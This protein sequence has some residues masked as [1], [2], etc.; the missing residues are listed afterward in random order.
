MKT[1]NFS[2][3]SRLFWGLHFALAM[4]QQTVRDSERLTKLSDGK[5]DVD[6]VEGILTRVVSVAVMALVGGALQTKPVIRMTAPVG[7]LTRQDL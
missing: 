3:M 2:R 1:A 6:D 5:C 7:R 4:A